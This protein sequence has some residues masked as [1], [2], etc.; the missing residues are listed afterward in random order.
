MSPEEAARKLDLELRRFRWFLSVGVGETHDG[1]A[2]FVYVR[3][4]NHP[5][6]ERFSEGWHGHKVLIRSV[7]AVRPVGADGNHRIVAS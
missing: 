3:S 4:K 5:E 2:L 7:G 6:L 1:P